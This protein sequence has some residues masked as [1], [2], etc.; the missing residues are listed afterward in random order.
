MRHS[1]PILT[2]NCH[3]HLGLM[4]IS[5]AVNALPEIQSAA[6]PMLMVVGQEGDSVAPTVA[7]ADGISV[8][9]R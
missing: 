4:D 2:A 6:M 3:T 1:T 8:G 9:V 5:G 7:L